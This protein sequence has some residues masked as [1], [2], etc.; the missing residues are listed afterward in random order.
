MVLITLNLL[1]EVAERNL[2][3]LNDE[4]DLQLSDTEANRDE[5]GG[6]PDETIFRNGSDVGLQLCKVGLIVYMN[7]STTLGESQRLSM[8]YPMA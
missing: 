5:F 4:V 6:S 1:L 2:L 7:I 8:T 3:I